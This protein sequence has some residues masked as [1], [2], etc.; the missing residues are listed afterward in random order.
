MK[1]FYLYHESIS[2]IETK[3]GVIGIRN[4]TFLPE[5]IE[6]VI[7]TIF[8]QDNNISFVFQEEELTKILKFNIYKRFLPN[9]RVENIE[10]FINESIKN[11]KTFYSFFAEGLLGL[12]CKDI[13]GYDLTTGLIDINDTLTDSHTGVDACLY[14]LQNNFIILGE[15]KFYD[16]LRGGINR[17]IDDFQ[18]KNILNKIDSQLRHARNNHNSN[19]II[20]KNLKKNLYDDITVEE[21]LQ[22]KIVFAGFVLHDHKISDNYLDKNFYSNFNLDKSKLIKNIGDLN[23]KLVNPNYEI[24]LLHLPVKSKKYLIKKVMEKARESIDKI[25]EENK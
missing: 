10:T 14:D 19:K 25:M 13:F 1:D 18:R 21:F 24:M 20:L 15:A 16:S 6:E 4:I 11:N 9:L 12:V 22:Q 5:V 3:Y 8:F 7:P 23:I 2:K 17:I